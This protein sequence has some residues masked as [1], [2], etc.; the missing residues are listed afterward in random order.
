MTKED[1]KR[2]LRQFID[3][4]NAGD[5]SV[6]DKLCAPEFVMHS[7]TLEGMTLEQ[8]KQYGK[9]LRAA[10]PDESFSIEDII[11][12]E[13]KIAVRYTWRGTHKGGFQ[14]IAPT[15][16]RVTSLVLETDRVSKGKFVETWICVDTASIMAQLGVVPSAAPK[17]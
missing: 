15:G 1:N 7:N 12:E 10:F 17:K 16:K 8:S 11:A 2:L 9:T 3:G 6:W 5:S 14:G 4:S 13:D